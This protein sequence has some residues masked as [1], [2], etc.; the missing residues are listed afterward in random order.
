M[1][2]RCALWGEKR[3][4]QSIIVTVSDLSY[5]IFPVVLGACAD[6][7]GFQLALWICVGFSVLAAFSAVPLYFS[8]QFKKGH[9][10][11]ES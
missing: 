10:T 2:D 11:A 5:A 4:M 6:Q 9:G 7:F 1:L 3:N 8:A